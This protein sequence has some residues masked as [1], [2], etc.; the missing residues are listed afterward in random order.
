MNLQLT[1]KICDYYRRHQ[2]NGAG[3]PGFLPLKASIWRW[4][5]VPIRKGRSSL[6]GSSPHNTVYRPMPYRPTSPSERS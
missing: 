3:M 2:G 4:L 5:T 6:H 1:D